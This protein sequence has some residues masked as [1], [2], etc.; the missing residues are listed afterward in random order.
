MTKSKHDNL[1]LIEEALRRYDAGE[2]LSRFFEEHKEIEQE[3]RAVLDVA[4][5]IG[6]LASAVTIPRAGLE[7]ALRDTNTS[8]NSVADMVTSPIGAITLWPIIVRFGVP[9]PAFAVIL[10][11]VVTT[12]TPSGSPGA[13]D[14]SS[15]Q[16]RS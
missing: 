13:F 2:D 12:T 6:V 10:L 9:A 15:A 1:M 3:V 14:L 11:M 16:M 7:R 5:K 8:S 4:Q